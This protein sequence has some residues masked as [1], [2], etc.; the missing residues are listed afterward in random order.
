VVGVDYR[1]HAAGYVAVTGSCPA[2][3]LQPHC[4]LLEKVAWQTVSNPG[5]SWY[6]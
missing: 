4:H 1:P 5:G 2:G 3:E 6:G